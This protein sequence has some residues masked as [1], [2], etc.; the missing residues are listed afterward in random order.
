MQSR[1]EVIT[2]SG[3]RIL[4]KT[5]NLLFLKFFSRRKSRSL[6]CLKR[7]RDDQYPLQASG[8]V[9]SAAQGS[10]ELRALLAPVKDGF[11]DAV[12]GLLRNH[13]RALRARVQI[14]QHLLRIAFEILAAL[15]HR[16][17]PF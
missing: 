12:H 3:S 5:R 4:R 7:T 11:A 15:P 2:R 16:F 8:S 13:A 6:V 10:A 14:F 1:D 9:L 17:D